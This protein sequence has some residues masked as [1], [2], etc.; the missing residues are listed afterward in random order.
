MIETK[1][2]AFH[3]GVIIKDAIDSLDMTQSEFANRV[4]LS[5]KNVST[6]VNGE[7]NITFGVAIKL[8]TFF[9]NSVE[10]WLNLQTNY[11]LY[12]YREKQNKEY[13]EDWEISKKISKEFIKKVLG[14][15][16]SNKFSTKNIDDLRRSFSVTSLSNL[17][18][19]DLYVFYHTSINK[20]IDEEMMMLRNA[21]ISIAEQK[22]RNIRCSTFNKDKIIENQK[23]LRC[24]TTL[25]PEVFLPR[26]KDFCNSCGVKLVILP[27]LSGSN[28]NGVT[29]WIDSEDCALVA[30][31]DCGKDADKFWF[32]LFHE[33]GHVIKNHKRHMTISLNKNDVLDGEEKEA[34]EFVENLLIDKEKYNEFVKRNDF[35]ISSINSFAKQQGVAPFIVIGRLQKDKYIPWSKYKEQKVKYNISLYI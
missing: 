12:L 11:D 18:R 5:V 7:S 13:A 20:E 4:G 33:F 30:V 1:R 23:K 15:E 14:I 27:Y 2:P 3:P 28:V 32:A 8:A 21:W 35:S 9:G 24:L 6:L 34:N 26:L 29:K 25:A 31:N 19:P 17:K 10:G 22:A 16:L